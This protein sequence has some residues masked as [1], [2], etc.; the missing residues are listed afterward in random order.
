MCDQEAEA[1]AR[2]ESQSM[3]RHAVGVLDAG[4]AAQVSARRSYA[5]DL[6][7]QIR[8]KKVGEVD[9]CFGY[10]FGLLPWSCLHLGAARWLLAS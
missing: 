9:W 7:E 1:I 4:Y 6:E 8:A 3:A 2:M 10:G 5:A